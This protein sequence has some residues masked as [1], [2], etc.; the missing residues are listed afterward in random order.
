MLRS[1]SFF[2]N[3]NTNEKKVDITTDAHDNLPILPINATNETDAEEFDVFDASG[4]DVFDTGGFDVCD[5]KE[6]DVSDSEESDFQDLPYAD[7]IQNIVD[8]RDLIIAIRPVNK[9][10]FQLIR[11]GYDTKSLKIKAKSSI[12]GVTAGFIVEEAAFGK[13]GKKDEE[14]QKQRIQKSLQ[15]KCGLVPLS[16]SNDRVSFLIKEKLIFIKSEYERQQVK[17]KQIESIYD[18]DRYTFELIQNKEKSNFWEVWHNNKS[19]MALTNPGQA[20]K[21]AAVT[22]DYDLFGIYP[23]KNQSVVNRPETIYPRVRTGSSPDIES[24]W[25]QCVGS[26]G[27]TE[28]AIAMDPEKGNVSIPEAKIIEELNEA[29]KKAGY[30]GKALIWHGTETANPDTPG[31]D[32]PISLFMPWETKISM[33]CNQRQLMEFY[34]HLEDSSYCAEQNAAFS[35]RPF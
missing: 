11:E 27:K 17:V 26:F 24:R 12:E 18:G 6:L 2:Q 7:A 21:K 35:M 22:A 13:N 19:V 14:K 8:K 16:I 15:A 10:A 30:K 20:G 31:P 23:N 29:I 34:H 9:M 5:S 33:I 28:S 32:F 4:F 25:Q 1:D 3:N